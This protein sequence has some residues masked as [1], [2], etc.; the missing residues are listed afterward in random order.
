MKLCKGL[1]Q[2]V[3]HFTGREEDVK[4]IIE[5]MKGSNPRLTVIIAAPGYGKTALA[6]EIGHEMYEKNELAVIYVSAR[7]QCLLEGLAKD[8]L[9]CLDKMPGNDPVHQVQFQLMALKKPTLLIIDNTEDLQ[10]VQGE[11]EKFSSF[12]EKLL[13]SK[14]A[15][16]LG[17]ILTTRVPLS[18]LLSFDY[19]EKKLKPLNEIPSAEL[20][21]HLTQSKGIVTKVWKDLA[22]ACGGIPL[23]IRIVASLIR[24]SYKPSALLEKLTNN[25]I[26]VLEIKHKAAKDYHE[27][28]LKFLRDTLEKDLLNALI[29][30]AVFPKDFSIQDATVV[31]EDKC[32]CEILFVRL[33]EHALLYENENGYML[34]P[35]IQSLCRD[36]AESSG[37]EE[38]ARNSQQKFNSHY[39]NMLDETQK[40]FKMLNS[41]NLA[42]KKFYANKLNIFQ[43]LYNCLKQEK[44]EETKGRCVFICITATDF[45]AKVITSDEF[46]KLYSHCSETAQKIKDR[47]MY[48]ALLTSLGFRHIIDSAHLKLNTK[49]L[50]T[51]QQA[52]NIQVNELSDE[53]LCNE[54]HAHCKSKLG[55]CFVMTGGEKVEKGITFVKEA[56]ELR[57]KLGEEIAIAAGY[58][59]LASKLLLNAPGTAKDENPQGGPSNWVDH[60]IYNMKTFIYSGIY[61]RKRPL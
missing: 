9:E 57:K 46:H 61:N 11:G 51:L 4:E 30:V 10:I 54:E 22:Q 38:E 56:L 55:L 14:N 53:Q 36:H 1:P 59:E 12:I 34:H 7:K 31:I 52:Y 13:N 27:S 28:L 45:L 25:P 35:L 33:V 47:Q 29:R 21:H 58:G 43:A 15:S 44:P 2:K 32:D 16:H 26:A 41:S 17:V 48:S 18:G 19:Q 3:K 6:T 37:K 42:I 40:Q 23:Y 49:A 50:E 5:N 8:I 20:L 24:G 39:V 60:I